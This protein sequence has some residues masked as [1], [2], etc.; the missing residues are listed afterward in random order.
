[1]AL[2]LQKFLLLSIL[3]H[4]KI[5][6]AQEDWGSS[7]G[8]PR[9][10]LQ[11]RFLHEQKELLCGIDGHWQFKVRLR[12]AATFCLFSAFKSM[13]DYCSSLDVYG[14]GAAKLSLRPARRGSQAI[15]NPMDIND[16]F[17]QSSTSKFQVFHYKAFLMNT[18]CFELQCQSDLLQT[19]PEWYSVPSPSS[20]GGWPVRYWSVIFGLRSQCSQSQVVHGS[21]ISTHDCQ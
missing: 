14:G 9:K 4:M 11:K 20:G 3:I 1:M 12:D 2:G 7:P 15:I 16:S 6:R 10:P 13:F 19:G 17:L 18:S 21:N 5:W 8:G